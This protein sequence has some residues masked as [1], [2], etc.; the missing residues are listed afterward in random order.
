MREGASLSA[1]FSTVGIFP[2]LISEM[3][4]IGEE[5]GTMPKVVNKVSSHYQMEMTTR[6]ERMIAAFEP[7]MIIMMGTVIGF[8]V[9][10]LFLP[11]FKIATISRG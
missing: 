10:A 1:E 11:L 5:T 9:I 6:V 8:L 4:K 3:T 2:L 7:L